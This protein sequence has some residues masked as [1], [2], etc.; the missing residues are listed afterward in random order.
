[1]IGRIRKL[2]K[3]RHPVVR[4][5]DRTD[6]GP[7]ALL[8]VLKFW[9]GNA[10]LVTVRELAQTD[11]T[12]TT[13]LSLLRAAESLGFRASGARGDLEHL[14][15]ASLPCI[16]HVVMEGGLPHYV[17]VY[18]ISGGSVLVGDPA[19]GLRSLSREDFMG[20]WITG[21][22]LLLSPTDHLQQ[23]T[24]PRW[25]PWV[26]SYVIREKVWLSQSVFLGVTYT[27]LGLISA[28]FVQ[29]L[30]DHLIPDRDVSRI[31]G[32]GAFLLVL[33]FLRALVGY[34][35]QRF[36]VEF[37]KRISVRIAADA[38]G[39]LFKLPTRFFESHKTGDVIARFND[40]VRIQAAVLRICGGTTI[41]LLIVIGS[42]MFLFAFAPP[43]A[44]AVL[45]VVP[46]LSM[47]LTIITRRIRSQQDEVMSSYACVESSYIESIA[48]IEAIRSF[49]SANSFSSLTKSL[50]DRYQ[51]RTAALGITHAQVALYA[52]VAVSALTVA[53][54]TGGAWLVIG[55]SLTLG[56]MMAAYALIAGV[57]PAAIRIVDGH[58]SLQEANVATRRLMDVLLVQPETNTGRERFVMR[59][60]LSISGGRFEWPKGGKLF[61]DLDLTLT[62]GHLIALCGASGAGKTT[63][64]KILERKYTLSGGELL[65]DDV[66]AHTVDL[67]DYRRHVAVLP[68]E[69]AMFNGTIAD[70]VLLGRSIAEPDD[71]LE[72]I[73]TK[74]LESLL[75][76][77][78]AGL[79]T[80]VGEH[81][82]RLSSGERQL[83]GLMRALIGSPSVLLIDEGMSAVDVETASMIIRI[84]I[85][86]AR[87]HTVL[88]VSHQLRTLLLADHV[89]VMS[90]GHVVEEG[91]PHDLARGPTEFSRLLD[92]QDSLARSA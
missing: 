23:S 14:K 84:L 63:V 73:R 88:I 8:S 42:V 47:L 80:I 28:L 55:R 58:L 31:V 29:Q 34:L 54:L 75:T 83:I 64:V 19:N 86:Y 72:R 20:I 74:S 44:W 46:P 50:Y 36:L 85:D 76:R 66:S 45:G 3:P 12:G 17:V 78:P 24:P 90:R 1:M 43:F 30:I 39:H 33:Q 48:N 7:A 9:G 60:S 57:M 53:A 67:E 89:Y 77:F 27:V 26:L 92:M 25:I 38:L 6:C 56:Q 79:R 41:D 71:L 13:L 70:N 40:T 62:R 81:G 69:V 11:V 51:E 32:F 87:Q 22:V 35:R 52:E 2:F 10:A 5:Y 49:N 37:N 68:G 21:A 82:H 91:N 65:V 61:E 59:R 18:R 4:Q 15:A 16:A